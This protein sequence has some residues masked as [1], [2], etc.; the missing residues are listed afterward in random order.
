MDSFISRNAL[1]AWAAVIAAFSH[2]PLALACAVC[3]TGQ[4]D[5]TA[6]TYLLSTA[7][8]SFI[9]LGLI[10]GVVWYVFKKAREQKP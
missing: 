5:P 8:L 9:P 10:G 3:G 7:L 1:L 2:A 6:N 4:R